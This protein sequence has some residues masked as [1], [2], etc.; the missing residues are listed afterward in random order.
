M[1]SIKDLLQD[2]R[3]SKRALEKL[4]ADMP[5]IMGTVA[6]NVVKDNFRLQGYDSGSGVIPW[7][8]RHEVTNKLYDRRVWV[9]GS[10]YSST[11]KLL[12]QSMTL[13]DGIKYEAQ[14]GRV[15]I[16]VDETLV[17]Y[18]KWMNEG[19]TGSMG[20][21]HITTHTPAR[22]FMPTPSEP[23]N[24]K[25]LKAV[26]KKVNYERDKALKLFKK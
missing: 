15:T 23:P 18:A 6:V 9:K 7:E 3:S 13:F 16:G 25:I 14:N 21:H 10:V 26:E 17:P 22:K 5:R 19:N 8:P 20:P 24:I 11:R 4:V 12:Q 1:K 2:W